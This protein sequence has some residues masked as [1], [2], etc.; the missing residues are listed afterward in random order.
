[1]I[2]A[3]GTSE[4]LSGRF[5]PWIKYFAADTTPSGAAVVL[6]PHAGGAAAAYRTLAVALSQ[7]GVDVYLMQY[8]QRADRLAHPAPASLEDLAAELF[9]AGDWASVGSLRLFGHCMGAVVGF[10]F[11]RVA[12]RHGVSVT[13][14]WASAG[15]AP[16]TVA[17]SPPVPDTDRELIADI[18]D[19]GGTDARLLDDED[20]VEL[21]LMAV[22]ADYT[23]WNA[24]ACD[25]AVRIRADVYVLGGSTDHRVDAEQLAAWENHTTGA[26]TVS[27]FDGG[28]FYLNDHVDT[29][30]ELMS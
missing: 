19:L 4:T 29:I 17:D 14:L 28:H 3:S 10:E 5:A 23:A 20:F 2:G 18:V 15:Q 12:E 11:A 30:A 16:C 7:R 22:R 27:M 26:F 8:P 21:L 13:E 24:Y 1:M 25:A 9:A 6:F